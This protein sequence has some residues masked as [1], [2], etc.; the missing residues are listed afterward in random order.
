MSAKVY[1]GNLSWNTTDDSL[2]NAF[3]SFGS[4]VDSIVMRDRDTGRSRGFGFVT[5]S[6]GQEAEAAIGGL[7]EQELDGRRIKVN[8]ANARAGG[9]GGGGGGGYGG[10]GGGYSGGGGGNY[11]GG[12]N[13]G[14]GGGGYGGGYQGGYGGSGGYSGGGGGY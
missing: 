7:N 6:S 3:S 12:Y 14:G 13:Q 9:G 10:G 8:M 5:Y 2:R 11:G 4:V 1:V